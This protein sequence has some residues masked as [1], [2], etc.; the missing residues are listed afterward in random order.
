METEQHVARHYERTGLEQAILDGLAAS[1]KDLDAIVPS[2]LS[3]VDEFHLGWR[4][5]TVEFARELGLSP[6]M[7]VLDIGCG[8]GG[9]ARYFAEAH[10]CTVM[11]IDLTPDYVAVAAALTRRC[12]LADRVS[13]EQGSALA[14]PFADAAFDAVTLIHVGMNIA[15]K[16]RLFA[17]ARRVL[18]AGGTFGIYD[19][20]RVGEGA[21]AYPT[22]WAQSAE[23]SFVEPS[24]VY[25]TRLGEA[26]FAIGK[27]RDRGDFAR[28]LGREMRE[29]AA[30]H[31]TPPL[32]LHIL[33]GPE[34]PQRLG[35]VMRA[36][37][38]GTIAPIEMVARAV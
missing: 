2:D 31:G 27:E 19:I 36:L 16:R 34:A 14:M 37:E 21:M 38:A 1:G 29:H 13:F 10:G 23:T 20:M 7:K 24:E 5:E 6:G 25:R 26:G 8:I 9:P 22:P 3:A 4:A 30:R 32:G 12:G 33:M 28:Q 35:N 17:E 18:G 11:G 15:D